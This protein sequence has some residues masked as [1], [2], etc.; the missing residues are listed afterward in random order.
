MSKRKTRYYKTFSD[1][2]VQSRRNYVFP[3][4]YVWIRTDKKYKVLSK[5]VYGC[6]LV[7]GRVYCACFLH[8]KIHGKEKLRT[9]RGGYFI[10]SNHTQPLGDVFLPALAAFPQRIY[11]V[12]GTD[13]YALPYIGKILPYLGAL[14]VAEGLQNVKKLRDAISCRITQ[15][16]P[17][18]IYPEA[19]VWEY[20]TKIRPFPDTSFAFPVKENKPAFA[21][22]VTY[23]KRR[24]KKPRAEVFLDGPFYP[25]GNTNKEKA[26]Y[27]HTQVSLA[28]QERSRN[29]NYDYIEYLPQP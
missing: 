18:V 28:M 4:D 7:F 6:A 26:A 15:G 14:P 22:T 2:F 16:H 19:H 20:Y 24:G 13:N 8:A 27:L 9:V 12:V 5:I 21:M 17:V 10:Y 29:S 25:V 3:K 23:T 11:T 1:D